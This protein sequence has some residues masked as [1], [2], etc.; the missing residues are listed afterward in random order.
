MITDEATKEEQHKATVTAT[1]DTYLQCALSANQRRRADYYALPLEE[2][3]LLAGDDGNNYRDLLN[4]VDGCLAKNNELVQ[5]M[6]AESP[7]PAIEDAALGAPAPTESEH[8]V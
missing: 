6:I 1:F 3:E 8:E 5:A 2:R 4:Q 7:F